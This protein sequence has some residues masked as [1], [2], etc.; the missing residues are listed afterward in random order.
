[1]AHQRALNRGVFARLAVAMTLLGVLVGV[2]FPFFAGLLGVPSRYANQPR[3]WTGCLT[4]GVVL[5]MC[6]WIVARR[7]IG[8]RLRTLAARLTVVGQH[9]RANALD[10]DWSLGSPQQ[11]QLP[12]G[13]RDDLGR[14]AAAFNSMLDAVDA[15]HRF[16]SLVQASSDISLLVDAAGLVT[17]AS[18][19]LTT[20]LG[21]PTKRALAHR[22]T[23]LVHPSDTKLVAEMFANL[24]EEPTEGS[25]PSAATLSVRARSMNGDWRRLE[26]TTSDRRADPHIL[27]FVVT[28]RDV[29]E[30]HQLQQ[31]LVRQSTHDD[32]TGLP[33]RSALL[34]V[35]EDLLQLGRQPRVAG[36]AALAIVVLD[37]DRFKEINDTLGHPCGDLLLTQIGPRLHK[38]LRAGDVLARL[39]GDEFAVL[40]PGLDRQTAFGAAHRLLS[41]FNAPFTIDGLDLHVEASLGVAVAEGR[42]LDDV[43]G[44]R[45]VIDGLLREADVAM[46]TAKELKTGVE[47]YD[48][49]AD[50]H[51]RLR[52][53]MLSQLRRGI[54]EGELLLHYQPK[55]DLT[56][57]ALVGVEAL[58]RW[59]HPTRGL[60]APGEFLPAVE[61]TGLI[62]P[63]TSAVLDLA[64][65]QA[66]TWLEAGHPVQVAVN[67]SARSLHQLDLPDR[68]HA[69]LAKHHV[70]AHLLRIELTE[71]ALMADPSKAMTILQRLHESGVALSV[72]DF[73]TGYSSMSY[74]KRLP[75]D[76]LKIDRIFVAGMANS[77]DDTVIVRSAVE[78][79]HNLGMK[80]VGE[81]IEHGPTAAKLA[82]MGCDIG[83]GYYFA[84]PA[85]AGELGAWLGAPA[86]TPTPA[87]EWVRAVD[88]LA[89]A[90]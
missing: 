30:R 41:A 28:A 78:L 84:R 15:E 83:Q 33:N 68:V 40:M 21:W 23:E 6:N 75:V 53:T 70:P 13:S 16:R 35:G 60:L 81:G 47:I 54:D 48:P 74:L 76:E 4:A 49:R 82:R 90:R 36:S 17:F 2:A 57:G 59:A 88:G 18:S 14:T 71:S 20:V 24:T 34:R 1:M 3:F 67:L 32:L 65:T 87:T 7:V 55:V 44:I 10:E 5:G 69:A 19:S 29:T 12:V 42:L 61:L 27:A 11:Y 26:V 79:G 85:P 77:R 86:R 31:R 62:T 51:N 72:D 63:L 80:V 58:V 38:L 9:L 66:H 73:G 39:G 64:L 25:L 43:G 46:Y 50:L 89:H 56:S 52:L 37:L 8:R 45:A 22:I